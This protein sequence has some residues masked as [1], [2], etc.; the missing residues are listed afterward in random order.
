MYEVALLSTLAQNCKTIKRPIF[1]S[2]QKKNRTAAPFADRKKVTA[3]PSV[4][5]GQN[6]KEMEL[7]STIGIIRG[8]HR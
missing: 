8:G 7:F 5:R 3:A 4:G 2:G 1:N 6:F